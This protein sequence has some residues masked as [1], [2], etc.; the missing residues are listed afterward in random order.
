MSTEAAVCGVVGDLL[1]AVWT[2]NHLG[3]LTDEAISLV[4]RTY[5]TQ[6][7]IVN[8]APCTAWRAWRICSTVRAI[9]RGR[10]F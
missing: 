10:N 9:G 3:K 6:A 8:E 2:L 1:V 4:A 5:A 7:E